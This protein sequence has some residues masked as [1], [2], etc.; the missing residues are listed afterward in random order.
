MSGIT[1]MTAA[2]SP[3]AETTAMIEGPSDAGEVLCSLICSEKDLTISC[4]QVATSQALPLTTS[5]ALPLSTAQASRFPHP[6]KE[7]QEPIVLVVWLVEEPVKGQVL[8]P[9]PL[10]LPLQV[11][12]AVKVTIEVEV[13]VLE[14]AAVRCMRR[15]GSAT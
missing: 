1:G 14:T 3:C 9:I 8:Q 12:V 13:E 7:S 2:E 15:S 10:R 4:V 6:T 5:Q 11:K